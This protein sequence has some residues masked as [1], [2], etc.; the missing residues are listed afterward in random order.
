MY[1]YKYA[2]HRVYILFTFSSCHCCFVRPI[3]PQETR[4]FG[5]LLGRSPLRE[6]RGWQ[7]QGPGA[8]EGGEGNQGHPQ[9]VCSSQGG[10]EMVRVEVGKNEEKWG[11]NRENGGWGTCLTHIQDLCPW[12]VTRPLAHDKSDR[13]NAGWLWKADLIFSRTSL[14][15]WATIVLAG[16]WFGGL[17]GQQLWRRRLQSCRGAVEGRSAALCGAACLLCLTGGWQ[18]GVLGCGGRRR[19]ILYGSWTEKDLAVVRG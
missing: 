19:W 3:G 10:L 17:L 14:F 13:E 8:T 11:Q 2:L 16:R 1:I 7:Q 18:H 6:F 15:F 5:G 12:Q 9:C 4:W